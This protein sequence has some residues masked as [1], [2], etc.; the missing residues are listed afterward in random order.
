MHCF[1]YSASIKVKFGIVNK[2]LYLLNFVS[3]LFLLSD[4]TASLAQW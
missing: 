3:L 4:W 2:P 1:K